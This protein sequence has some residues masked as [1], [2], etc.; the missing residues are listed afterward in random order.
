MQDIRPDQALGSAV[1]S[2]G[3]TLVIKVNHASIYFEKH[4][5]FAHYQYQFLHKHFART[6]IDE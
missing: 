4:A 3:N 5:E 1:Y 6:A 2:A